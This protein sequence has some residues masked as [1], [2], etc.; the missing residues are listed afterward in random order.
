MD[1]MILHKWFHENHIVLYPGKCHYIL[2]SDNDPI[3]KVI[4]NNNEIASSNEKKLL[5]IFLV[6]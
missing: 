2:I 3:H 4:L 5:G 6:T 1:S